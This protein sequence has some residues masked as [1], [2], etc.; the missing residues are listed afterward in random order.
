VADARQNET[1]NAISQHHY[2]RLTQ[3][4]E[5]TKSHPDMSCD[6]NGNFPKFQMTGGHHLENG[7]ISI[8]QLRIVQF[9]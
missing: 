1:F 3:N 8:S 5:E 4:L 2:V 7:L 9:R 6:L